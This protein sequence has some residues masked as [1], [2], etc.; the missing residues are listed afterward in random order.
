MKLLHAYDLPIPDGTTL[1][2]IHCADISLP[3]PLMCLVTSS[4]FFC[5]MIFIMCIMLCHG[6]GNGGS[7]CVEETI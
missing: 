7:D 4:S 6:T 5:I 3:F 1:V 2:I